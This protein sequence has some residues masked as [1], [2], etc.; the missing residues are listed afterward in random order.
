MVKDHY[1]TLSDKKYP[2]FVLRE[3]IR[4]SG[5]EVW[6]WGDP[7]EQLFVHKMSEVLRVLMI[8]KLLSTGPELERGSIDLYNKYVHYVHTNE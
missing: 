5:R 8:F 1:S 4:G 2:T 6:S 3:A 7:M